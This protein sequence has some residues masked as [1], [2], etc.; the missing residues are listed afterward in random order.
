[1]NSRFVGVKKILVIKLRHIGDVLLAVPVFRALKETFPGTHITTIVNSGTDGVL[2]GYPLIDEIITLDRG[3]KDLP[4]KER[5]AREADFLLKIRAEKFD[6][7]VDLTGGDRAAILSYTSGARYRIGWESSRGFAGKR[8]LYTHRHKPDIRAHM[9]LQNL[10]VVRSFGITTANI[11][12]DFH[13]PEADRDFGDKILGNRTA[14]GRP[15]VHIHPTSR[16]LFKCWTDDL[17]SE[18][19]TWL[20][21]DN[22]TVIMTS[23]EDHREMARAE[24]ILSKVG[25][26]PELINLCGRTTLKQLGAISRRADL[27][28]GVDSAPMHIAAAVGTPV[29]A[30]FGPTGAFNWGPWHNGGAGSDD[31]YRLKNGIQ[32]CGKHTV[33]QKTWDCV[34]CGK[35]GCEGSKISKCLEGIAV[36]EV[37]DVLEEKLR[38]VV[39]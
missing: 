30:L 39:R 19:I 7:A 1:M 28:F 22:K 15:I 27:F 8:H 21:K 14:P 17:M 35:D 18:I 31:S 34:P 29:L 9:V 25:P 5:Y 10:D 20:L 3:I 4:L 11:A 33:I 24:E 32:N 2:R 23:S 12:V 13:I 38:A 37:K 6:M 36:D 16:W 26:H